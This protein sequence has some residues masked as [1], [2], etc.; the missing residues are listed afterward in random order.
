MITGFNL[1]DMYAADHIK[2]VLLTL[3]G[4]FMGIGEF[5]NH[6]DADMPF[7]RPDQEPYMLVQFKDLLLKH[8][9]TTVIWAHAGLGR[10]VRPVKD[11][12]GI[13]DRALANPG[14]KNLHIDIS[15]DETAKYVTASPETVGAT[16]ALI[17][18]YLTASCL[19]RMLWRLRASTRLWPSTMHTN[20]CG[21]PYA[22]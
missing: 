14:L 2:R 13:L 12:L 17:E 10:I 11:H 6:N 1:A 20:R 5:S 18:K 7:P 8:P 19:G 3:P 16:A 9:N 4:V 15:W 22:L 21:G